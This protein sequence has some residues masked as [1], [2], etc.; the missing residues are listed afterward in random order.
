MREIIDARGLS[1]PE[2]VIRVKKALEKTNVVEA[3]V[4][5]ETALGNLIRLAAV[6]GCS[7]QHEKTE[8]GSYRILIVKTAS[9]PEQPSCTFVE[10]AIGPAVISLSSDTMGRGDNALGATL[11]KA[12]VHTITEITPLPD[13]IVLYNTGVKLAVSDTQSAEDLKAL[14]DKGV[15]I[16]ICGTC[17]NFFELSDKIF[18]GTIS[19]MYDIAGAL[20]SSGRI[21]CP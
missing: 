7:E 10:S 15:K 17:V 18:V 1:C 14:S 12:F 2:P 4:N 3:L 13:I 19:N 6:S 21:V 11:M 5:N 8:D 9:A 16:L 20:S